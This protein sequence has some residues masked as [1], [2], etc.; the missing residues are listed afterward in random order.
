MCTV[1]FVCANGRIII[2]SNRDEQIGRPS[3]PPKNYLIN[4]KK[5]IFPKDPKAGGTWF[6]VDD[7]AT[8]LVLLN[9][10]AENTNGNRLIEEVED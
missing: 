10:A 4:N 6:V 2:T 7:D 3:N 5:I 1:S 8:V 9:G